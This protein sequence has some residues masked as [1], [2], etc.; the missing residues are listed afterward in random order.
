[1]LGIF[2]SR[3]RRCV[4]G[5]GTLCGYLDSWPIWPCGLDGN[6]GRQYG[7]CFLMGIFV[8]LLAFPSIYPSH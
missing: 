5:N 8:A 3:R 1:M 7:G 4:R 6:A 2:I